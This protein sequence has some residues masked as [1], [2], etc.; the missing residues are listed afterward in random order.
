VSFDPSGKQRWVQHTD[1]QMGQL[2]LD[3]SGNVYVIGSGGGGPFREWVIIKYTTGGQ[4]VWERH[5]QGTADED[6]LVTDIQLDPAGNPIVLGTTNNSPSLSNNVTTVKFDP[7]GNTLWVQDFNAIPQVGQR[8]QGLAVDGSGSV[9]ITGTT[10]PPEGPFT[11][12]TVKYDTN[13]NP[14]FVLLGDGVGGTAVAI[15]AAGDVLL[16]GVHLVR[17]LPDVVTASKLHADGTM[18]FVTRIGAAGKILPDSAGNIFVAATIVDTGEP[19]Y[20][21]TKLDPSGKEIFH[22][23]FQPGADV[24]DAA[25]D[26]F[27]SLIVTGSGDFIGNLDIFTLKFPKNFT[28]LVR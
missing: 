19:D 8:P 21:I 25:I 1:G 14:K 24:D 18:V 6:S 12:F 10:I 3:G 13:G 26:P 22:F 15:D 7:Q 5:H 9:Y 2:V 16:S 27:G 23:R 28:A 17:G 4:V 11:P 20:F